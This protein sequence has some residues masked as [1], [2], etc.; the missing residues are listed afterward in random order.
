MKVLA[1]ALLVGC[2]SQ[3]ATQ[4]PP[5]PPAPTS[6]TPAPV[7]PEKPVSTTVGS[8]DLVGLENLIPMMRD[9][10]AHRPT[11][12]VTPEKLFD[13]LGI[14][15]RKQILARSAD[16]KFCALGKVNANGL[17]GVVA[18][19]YD[20]AAS[21]IAA[22]DKMNGS[23]IANVSRQVRGQTLVTVTNVEANRDQ[24]RRVYEV[25]KSL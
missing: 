19:E 23:R 6:P 1:L 22:R 10:A 2:S 18:C 4:S 7:V 8:K 3:A 20:T 14:Q 25:L 9:E 24:E 13:A 5:A 15:Q 16:A 11:V 21:A 12:E 17:V